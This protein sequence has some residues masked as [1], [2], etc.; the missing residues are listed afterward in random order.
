MRPVHS[1]RSRH[2]LLESMVYSKIGNDDPIQHDIPTIRT[3][4]VIWILFFRFFV[5]T[6]PR[7]AMAVFCFAEC[8]VLVQ[9]TRRYAIVPQ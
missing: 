3:L 6:L 8:I 2:V 1:T 9:N 4:V 5:A 7:D